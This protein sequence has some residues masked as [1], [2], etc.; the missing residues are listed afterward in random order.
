MNAAKQTAMDTYGFTEWPYPP[1]RTPHAADCRGLACKLMRE[2]GVLAKIVSYEVGFA[3][4][5][6]VHWAIKRYEGMV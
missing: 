1:L 2:A 4:P 6:S 3:D 5:C